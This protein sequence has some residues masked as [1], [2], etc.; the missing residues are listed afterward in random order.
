MTGYSIEK[1]FGKMLLATIAAVGFGM[2]M[3]AVSATNITGHVV[4]AAD[5]DWRGL[6]PVA[7]AEGATLN[8]NE[9]TLKVDALAQTLDPGE[10]VTSSDGVVTTTTE[11][12]KG[13]GP[14][15]CLFDNVFERTQ[16]H[17]ILSWKNT[18]N[19]TY[20]FGAGNEKCLRAYKIYFA[21]TSGRAPK[22][23]K[24]EGS[25]D[26]DN[27]TT[28]DNRVG[29]IGWGSSDTRTFSFYNQTSY[30]YYRFSVSATESGADFLELYQLEYFTSPA[31]YFDPADLTIP[32][33]TR[34]SSSAL[35]SGTSATNLFDNN[36]TYSSS[37]RLLKSG[38]PCDVVY[39]FGDGG[40]AVNGYKIY[41]VGKSR[42]PVDWQFE[43]SNDNENWTILDIRE[44]ETNWT[45]GV[46]R[47]FWFANATSYR[48][49]R[50]RV[51][52]F[53]SD[54]YYLE[55]Y[56]LEYFCRPSVLS[57]SA[58]SGIDLTVNGGGNVSSLSGSPSV[59]NV[60]CLFDNTMTYSSS[61]RILFYYQYNS[62]FN[63]IY[64]FGA[65]VQTNVSSYRVYSSQ[66][67][68]KEWTFDASNDNA[69]WTKLD[70]QEGVDSWP[71]SNIRTSSFKNENSY[72]YYR[73]Q[74][75]RP[76]GVT[77]GA[78]ELYQLEFLGGEKNGG[79]IVNVAAE[80]AQTNACIALDGALRLVKT[81]DGSFTAAFAKQTYSGGTVVSNGTFVAGLAGDSAPLG[82]Q[83]GT[84]EESSIVTVCAGALFDANGFGGW[85]NY[86]F[87]L[88]G[89]TLRCDMAETG[90]P[91]NT[92]RYVAL[93]SDSRLEVEGNFVMGDGTGEQGCLDLDGH[94]LTT[95]VS[96][97]GLWTL[98]LPQVTAGTI[99]FD[100]KKGDA[101]GGKKVL[102]WTDGA[103]PAGVIF[104]KSESGY[105][106]VSSRSDGVYVVPK[107]MLIVFQ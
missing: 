48:Y 49:Y 24:F 88:D 44:G 26:T 79:L 103:A 45:N 16:D 74:I 14:V 11:L 96:S 12:S 89:G 19:V 68:P 107:G 76:A 72:R 1:L 85:Y 46:G 36:F 106:N 83:N 66:N 8:L 59:G 58:L 60:A 31:E 90:A 71:S 56:Q 73:L 39:D 43:G 29:E 100:L 10:D 7:L 9:H 65:G 63:I 80:T 21:G 78:V 18:F 87:R 54:N 55:L 25:D 20:D 57:K 42:A 70:S 62:L 37:H 61:H 97:S 47:D 99:A 40:E 27:W 53:G 86:P 50:L 28:L 13:S 17:R 69:N 94:A 41:A 77:E 2:P 51:T 30:R 4:L 104:T 82:L 33:P 105:Y 38:A 32:D 15:S 22:N 5:A 52:K 98:N 102:A 3:A 6:G 75:K 93:D 91:S 34:V 95:S 101:P 81:G 67:R 84:D 35:S 23:W 92:F 64:D